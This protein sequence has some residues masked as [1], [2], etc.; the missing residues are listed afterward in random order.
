[1]GAQVL[2]IVDLDAAFSGTFSNHDTVAR[3]MKTIRIPVQ[4]GGGVRTIEDVDVRLDGLGIF[5]VIIGTAAF[6]NPDLVSEAV[7]KYPGRIIIGID[8]KDGKVATRG[9][10][11]STETG[12]ISL[13][14]EIKKHGIETVVYTDIARDG[15]LAGPNIKGIAEMIK[16]TGM[17]IIASGGISVI[18]DIKRVMDTG[19]KG[20]IIGKA[21][22]AGSINFRDAIQM[23]AGGC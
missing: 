19:A 14:L 12:P 18:D 6:E 20:L 8:A 13:A 17:D 10:T 23:E 11:T 9:W 3:I 1:M 15:M 7:K 5:R 22:Y 16:N 21:L 4:L 2:H